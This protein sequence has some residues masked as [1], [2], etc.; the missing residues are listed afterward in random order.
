MRRA[1][2]SIEVAAPRRAAGGGA[3]A[4]L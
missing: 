3:R 2:P 4:R 1:A